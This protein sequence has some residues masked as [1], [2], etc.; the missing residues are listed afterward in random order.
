MR[1]KVLL[2]VQNPL[3]F[4]LRQLFK[5][6][7]FSS[8]LL[9]LLFLKLNDLV[10]LQFEVFL[11][12]LDVVDVF[13]KQDFLYVELLS[14]LAVIR[15]S[16]SFHL[17]LVKESFNLITLPCNWSESLVLIQRS[18]GW[19]NCDLCVVTVI[20]FNRVVFA[21]STDYIL[22]KLIPNFPNLIQ[23]QMK[24]SWNF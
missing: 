11:K 14:K 9:F 15:S 23:I 18:L 13:G 8:W 10:L 20:I 6:G 5:Q 2:S 7:L 12:S 21:E 1:F 16:N 19:S 22:L 17:F 3:V 24:S 4:K